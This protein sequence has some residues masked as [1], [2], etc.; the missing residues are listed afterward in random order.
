MTG[1]QNAGESSGE[2]FSCS[3]GGLNVS[4]V[5]EGVGGGVFEG[6]HA[7]L[8]PFR[9]DVSTADLRVRVRPVEPAPGPVEAEEDLARALWA[10]MHRFPGEERAEH[11]LPIR[12]RHA[13]KFAGR[14]EVESLYRRCAE[15]GWHE[16]LAFFGDRGPSIHFPGRGEAEIFLRPPVRALDASHLQ[17][18]LFQILSAELA[19]RDGLLV[20][21]S[22]VVL[23]GKSHVFLGLSGAGKSTAG[24]LAGGPLFADDGLILRRVRGAFRAFATPFCQ[25]KESEAWLEGIA[26]GSA[27]IR[28]LHFLDQAKEHALSPVPGPEAALMILQHYIHYY[29]LLPDRPAEN[30]FCTAC[31][32]VKE[33]PVQTLHFR[34]DPGFLAIIDPK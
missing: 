25:Q 21:G 28:G 30:A 27:P 12:L 34:K 33:H 31:A 8:E 1:L 23:S 22:A 24:R 18:R 13:R 6:F 11:W 29:R 3:L 15:T 4:F 5:F 17:A 20:H 14:P 32:L 2:R 16:V 19:T 26:L 10:P 9:T 7:F